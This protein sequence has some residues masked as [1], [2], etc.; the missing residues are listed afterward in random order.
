MQASD[1]KKQLFNGILFNNERGVSLS[2]MRKLVTCLQIY[3][4]NFC[5]MH[6]MLRA[7]I[8]AICKYRKCYEILLQK[9]EKRSRVYAISV[10]IEAT[11]ILPQYCIL[12]IVYIQRE[13]LYAK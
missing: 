4:Y 3:T 1:T 13:L 5:A 10:Q 12:Y 9:N 11:T 7:I 8:F 2:Y 6:F